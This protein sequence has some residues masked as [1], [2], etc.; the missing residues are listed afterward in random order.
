MRGQEL[1]AEAAERVHTDQDVTAHAELL[2]IRHACQVLGTTNLSGCTLYTNVEPCW[3]CAFAIRETQISR[4]VIDKPI[5]GIG[6]V[7]SRYPILT[8]SEVPDWGT[9]PTIVWRADEAAT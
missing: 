7:T 1:I 3:M 8:D 5:E 9:P 2:A 6:G 4:V